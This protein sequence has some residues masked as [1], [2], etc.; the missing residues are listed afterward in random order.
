MPAR[1][2]NKC[3]TSVTEEHI[4]IL[5]STSKG[6]VHLLTLETLS[7]YILELEPEINTKLKV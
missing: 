2:L 1:R 4:D 7:I 6:E 5:A 3:N